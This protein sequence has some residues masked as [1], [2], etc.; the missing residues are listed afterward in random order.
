MTLFA[1]AYLMWIA[2]I[3]VAQGLLFVLCFYGLLRL[4][5]VL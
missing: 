3:P 1:L 5:G 4:V 2:C